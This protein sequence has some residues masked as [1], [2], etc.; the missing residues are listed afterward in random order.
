MSET[1]LKPKKKYLQN[2]YG[3][4]KYKYRSRQKHI[5]FWLSMP[6]KLAN[7]NKGISECPLQPPFSLSHFSKALPSRYRPAD[8]PFAPRLEVVFRALYGS[9]F[10]SFLSFT[11]RVFLPPP[12]PRDLKPRSISDGKNFRAINFTPLK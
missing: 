11:L 12:A 4:K 8:K 10:D 6:Y 9:L 7:P 3:S 5:V 1:R 2:A